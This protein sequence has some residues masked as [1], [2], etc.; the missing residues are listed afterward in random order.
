MNS[1]SPGRHLLSSCSSRMKWSGI[2]QLSPP[3]LK[4]NSQQAIVSHFKKEHREGVCGEGGRVSGGILAGTGGQP[5][6]HRKRGAESAQVSPRRDNEAHHSVSPFPSL[7]EAKLQFGFTSPLYSSRSYTA[8]TPTAESPDDSDVSF[9]P[10]ISIDNLLSLL[11]A[12]PTICLKVISPE[13]SRYLMGLFH[14][15][16]L[17]LTLGG[18]EPLAGRQEL[19]RVIVGGE[20]PEE[21]KARELRGC[22]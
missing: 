1:C 18:G 6:D 14:V 2:Q 17:Y 21:T 8:S 5:P 13:Y 9:H 10:R 12:S 7:S 4:M 16:T 15:I 11:L 3:W 19:R 22:M 20:F